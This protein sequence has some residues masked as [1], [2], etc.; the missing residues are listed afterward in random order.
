[1]N[2][3]YFSWFMKSRNKFATCR[4]VDDCYFCKGEGEVEVKGKEHEERTEDCDMC[5]GTGIDQ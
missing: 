5:N 1:M 3:K 4:G 2:I